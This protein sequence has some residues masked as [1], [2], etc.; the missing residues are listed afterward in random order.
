MCSASPTPRQTASLSLARERLGAMDPME[1]AHRAHV[2][3]NRR[4]ETRCQTAKA[5]HAEGRRSEAEGC[6]E[7]PFLGSRFRVTYPGGIVEPANADYPPKHAHSL[8]MLHYLAHADGHVMA[9]RW[10]TFRELPDGLMYDRA[11]RARVEPPLLAA[12][13]SRPDLFRSASR[14][15]GGSPI[16]FGDAGFMFSVLPRVRMAVVLHLGDDEFPPAVRVL[17][18]AAAGH[19]LPTEDLAVLGGLLVGALLKAAPR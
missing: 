4:D 16:D 7:L 9:D 18:D 6:F 15:L 11:F 10:A 17:Y 19:Y 13:G 12:F 8:L 14:A 3:Y 5:C 1:I 2:K